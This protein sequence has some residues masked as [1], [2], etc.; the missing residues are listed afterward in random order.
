MVLKTDATD[1]H[2]LCGSHP[3]FSNSVMILDNFLVFLKHLHSDL[4]NF[5]FLCTETFCSQSHLLLNH[6]KSSVALLKVNTDYKQVCAIDSY[7]ASIK[8]N[9][10]FLILT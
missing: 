5:S 1:L 9:A 10:L 6:G 3:I 4:N 8:F 2:S 7:N